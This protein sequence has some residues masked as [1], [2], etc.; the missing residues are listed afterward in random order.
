LKYANK[1]FS[2]EEN[3]WFSLKTREKLFSRA[4]YSYIC[5]IENTEKFAKQLLTTIFR[6]KAQRKKDLEGK[7]FPAS[8]T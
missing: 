8:L 7:I 4:D 3:Q 5:S 6:K 2:S 1:T